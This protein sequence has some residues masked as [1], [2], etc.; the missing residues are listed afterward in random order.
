MT[1]RLFFSLSV[2]GFSARLG[3][4]D[5]W[6][7]R[8]GIGR[9]AAKG[10][11]V[12]FVL[13]KPAQEE[14]AAIDD[15][16][17]RALEVLPLVLAG[18]TQGAMLKLHTKEQEERVERPDTVARTAKAE[19]AGDPVRKAVEAAET[20][21]A[22]PPEIPAMD[23]PGAPSEKPA[24]PAGETGAGKPGGLNS[25]LKKFLPGADSPRKK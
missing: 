18:D 23:R 9:P 20:R 16:I 25:L 11:A 21:P 8:L 22:A 3:T 4:H 1:E 6:R 24:T 12:E 15:A 2:Y 19:A 14:R 7:L 17:E 13:H 5:Y 10:A